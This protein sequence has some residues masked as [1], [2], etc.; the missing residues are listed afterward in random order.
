[1]K[2]LVTRSCPTLCDL[3]DRLFCPW[4]SPGKNTRV[5][6]HSLFQGIFMTQ[7]LNLGFLYC[8]QILYRLS[9]WGSIHTHTHT[10]T[11]DIFF[12]RSSIEEHLGCF[13]FIAVVSNAATNTSVH[14]SFVC[15]FCSLW[16]NTKLLYLMVTLCLILE[17]I[18]TAL[19][20]KMAIPFCTPTSNGW[21][22]LLFYNL[23]SIWCCQ[24]LSF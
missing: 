12:I 18:T 23:A 20:S 2:A 14:I 7:W 22:F 1:M 19:S 4:K 11:H 24:C 15:V 8:R 17:E 21:V 3:M 10:H 5:G 13:H 6:S 16:V 9:H